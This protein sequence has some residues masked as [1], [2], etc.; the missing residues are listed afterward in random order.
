MPATDEAGAALIA[1]RLRA[2]IEN[3]LIPHQASGLGH[4]TISGGTATLRPFARREVPAMLVAAADRAL[5]EAKTSGR[6]RIR[7]GAAVVDLADPLTAAGLG[8]PHAIATPAI[9]T[10][11]IATQ[12]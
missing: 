1:Q 11:A 4:V 9:A 7:A 8:L 6:N 3:L 2:G 5:Y 10:Q 12:A